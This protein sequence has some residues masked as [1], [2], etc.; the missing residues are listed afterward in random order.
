MDRRSS[1]PTYEEAM[2]ICKPATNPQ[3]NIRIEVHRPNLNLP[4]P[5]SVE[6]STSGMRCATCSG[7]LEITVKYHI[8]CDTHI[9][10]LAIFIPIL[11]GVLILIHFDIFPLKYILLSFLPITLICYYLKGCRQPRNYCSFCDNR[12]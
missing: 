5:N 1:L 2:R 11:I 10:F 6:N 8:T 4:N 7:P 12:V 3:T 9:T